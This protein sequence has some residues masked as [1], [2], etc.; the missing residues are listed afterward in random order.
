MAIDLFGQRGDR[1]G[2][3]IYYNSRSSD[4]MALGGLQPNLDSDPGL[5][6]TPPHLLTSRRTCHWPK[7]DPEVRLVAATPP[8][9]LGQRV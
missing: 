3:V 7:P 9:S 2:L 5:C 6:H 4:P 8:Q 1:F